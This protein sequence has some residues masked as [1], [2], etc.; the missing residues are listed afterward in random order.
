[1]VRPELRREI[2]SALE[3]SKL[4]A[5][6][7]KFDSTISFESGKGRKAIEVLQEMLRSRK[8]S[9]LFPLFARRAIAEG[10]VG[11]YRVSIG[12]EGRDWRWLR[13][14]SWGEVMQ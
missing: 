3:V 12:M 10:N 11:M 2:A 1:M 13:G 14:I 4:T 5:R 8:Q 9:L 6:S 7:I